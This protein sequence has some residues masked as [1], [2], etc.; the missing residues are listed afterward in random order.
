MTVLTPDEI[1]KIQSELESDRLTWETHW[2]E[3]QDFILP[4]RAP[5]IGFRQPGDRDDQVA[6]FDS[7]GQVSNELLA[8]ALQGL[9]TSPNTQWFELTTGDPELDDDDDIRVWL[10]DSSRRML[11]VLNNSNFQ[12][13]IHEVY[14]DLTSIG[15]APMSMEEDDITLIRFRARPI[16][17]V[18]IRENHLGIVDELHRKFEMKARD[19]VAEFIP[20]GEDPTEAR[21]GKRIMQSLADIKKME[22]KHTII[23]AVYPRDIPNPDQL[24]KKFVSQFIVKSDKKELSIGGF[25]EFPFVVPRW[26]K[27]AGEMYGRSPGMTALPE[28]KMINEMERTQIEA[29]QKTVDPPIAVQDDGVLSPIDL[30]PGGLTFIRPGSEFPKPILN[31]VRLDLGEK[32]LEQRRQRIREAFF[33]DQLQLGA[34]PQMTATEVLQRT[35]E[36]M[37]LLGP[38]LGRQQ[39]EL[40]RP[41]IDRLF[42]IMLRRGKLRPIPVKLRRREGFKLDVQYSSMIARTQRN[43]ETQ[44]ILRAVE[45][46]TPF[47]QADPSGFDNIDIDKT[48]RGIWRLFN[49]PQEM[50]RSEADRD[51][52]RRE[53]AKAQAA[54]QQAEQAAQQAD[55]VSKVGP[56][57]VQAQVG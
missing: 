25:N 14:M 37:R 4:R 21:L 56:T 11:N 40:L 55:V 15:T 17:E 36:K 35:E 42:E 16:K 8:G 57:L 12:T 38:L 43:T 41:L 34:G 44:S 28:I 29:A 5:V 52:I 10:Q 1:I 50:L 9:L 20:P 22:K 2:Q 49:A 46:A 27:S 48:V 32:M 13:E 39:A 33:V 30:T 45:A 51:S 19:I 31:N 53:R 54:Q 3:L 24:N 18:F 47:I 26:S 23:H 7:T 6:L